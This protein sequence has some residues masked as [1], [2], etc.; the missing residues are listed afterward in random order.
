MLLSLSLLPVIL[1]LERVKQALLILQMV[2]L[3]FM[4]LRS[5][6]SPLGKLFFIMLGQVLIQVWIDHQYF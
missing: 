4:A 5:S 3:R 6:N 1:G 2:P